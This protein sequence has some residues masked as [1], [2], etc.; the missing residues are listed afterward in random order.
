MNKLKHYNEN[1]IQDLYNKYSIPYD[2]PKN[3]LS[4]K[5][6]C[7][8][9]N[10]RL[11]ATFPAM[12]CQLAC[13]KA[14]PIFDPF[15]MNAD[16]AQLC[17]IWRTD[18]HFRPQKHLED[19]LTSKE[20]PIPR[21]EVFFRLSLRPRKPYTKKQKTRNITLGITTELFSASPRYKFPYLPQHS[22]EKHWKPRTIS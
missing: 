10:K 21:P 12:S 6:T 2:R 18:N 16:Y 9:R 4:Y 17:H 15:S 13:I 8:N 3:R 5:R 20:Q 22:A 19:T 14:S 11:L 7:M 1:Y